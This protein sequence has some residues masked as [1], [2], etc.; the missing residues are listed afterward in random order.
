[1]GFAEEKSEKNIL[2]LF[3]SKKS[4]KNIFLLTVIFQ[5]FRPR[6]PMTHQCQNVPRILPSVG[7][8][9]LFKIFFS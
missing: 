7:H 1:M 2:S 6:A 3:Q 5:R 8:K 9:N 4:G